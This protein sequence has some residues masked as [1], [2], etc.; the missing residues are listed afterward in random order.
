MHKLFNYA[1]RVSMTVLS[2]ALILT[3]VPIGVF[4]AEIDENPVIIDAAD[5]DK[6]VE[7]V[8]DTTTESEPATKA[9]NE[10]EASQEDELL[11]D[12]VSS[13][14]S[15]TVDV[16]F[17]CQNASVSAYDNYDAI[18]DNKVAVATGNDY[19]FMV[20]ADNGYL[21]KSV[22][23]GD[24]AVAE[25]DGVYTISNITAA[26]TV[27][28]IAVAQGYPTLEELAGQITTATLVDHKE[29]GGLSSDEIIEDYSLTT[30]TGEMM[31]YNGLINVTVSGK[32]LKSHANSKGQNAYWLGI[33]LPQPAE[34]SLYTAQYVSGY[35]KEGYEN[36]FFDADD[37][38]DS[39]DIFYFGT[40]SYATPISEGYVIVEYTNIETDYAVQYMIHVD[41]SEVTFFD[42][43]PT[44]AE[45]AANI[46]KAPLVDRDGKYE[47]EDIAQNYSVTTDEPNPDSD[48]VTVHLKADNLLKHKAGGDAGMGY[49]AGIA[50]PEIVG[51]EFTTEYS[52]DPSSEYY[53]YGSDPSWSS[54]LDDVLRDAQGNI[55]HRTVYFNAAKI[56]AGSGSSYGYVYVKYTSK[57]DSNVS[58]IYRIAVSFE[59]VNIGMVD[60]AIA[61][62]VVA[63]NLGDGNKT[64][65]DLVDDYA[66][67]VEPEEGW[68]VTQGDKEL[69]YTVPVKV[70]AHNL[71]LHNAPGAGAGYWVG[72]GIPQA[73]RQ[74][75]DESK[76]SDKKKFGQYI[77]SR[78]YVGWTPADRSW[79]I[80]DPRA[81]VMDDEQ[82]T[83]GW[84]YDTTLF[85]V[86]KYAGTGK[87]AYVEVRVVDSN[88]EHP[89]AASTYGKGEA[90]IKYELDFSDVTLAETNYDVQITE[91]L[92][93]AKLY[94][95]QSGG[96]DPEITLTATVKDEKGNLAKNVPVAW[97]SDKENIIEFK[98]NDHSYARKYSTST[99]ENGVATAVVRINTSY[100]EAAVANVTATAGGSGMDSVSYELYKENGNL[101]SSTT[102]VTLVR[103]SMTSYSLIPTFT[104]ADDSHYV[105]KWSAVTSADDPT[106]SVDDN[107]I[108]TALKDGTT[109]FKQGIYKENGEL[110]GAGLETEGIYKITVVTSIERVSIRQ[111]QEI[112]A[113]GKMAGGVFFAD[114]YPQKNKNLAYK[115]ESSNTDVLEFMFD[116]DRVPEVTSTKKGAVTVRLTVTDNETGKTYS[117]SKVV[118]V[119][120]AAKDFTVYRQGDYANRA[121]VYPSYTGYVDIP[122]GDSVKFLTEIIAEEGIDKTVKWYS[123]NPAV[124]TVDQSGIVTAVSAGDTIIE[125]YLVDGSDV[126]IQLRVVS[127]ATSISTDQKVINIPQ[128]NGGTAE[129]TLSYEPA[130]ASMPP[131]Y[132]VVGEPKCVTVEPSGG[133]SYTL[134]A[135]K[136]GKETITFRDWMTGLTAS[137][138]VN[139]GTNVKPAT[140]LTTGI[141]EYNIYAGK[142]IQLTYEVTPKDCSNV[143]YNWAVT[144]GDDK[145]SVSDK[146][147]VSVKN[148]VE[149]GECEVTL[150]AVNEDSSL[151]PVTTT[152]KINVQPLPV[153]QSIV[154]EPRSLTLNAPLGDN[155]VETATLSAKV[156]PENAFYSDIKWTSSNEKVVKVH[157]YNTGLI[158]AESEGTATVTATVYKAGVEVVSTSIPV[159]VVSDVDPI[160]YE[161]GRYNE[162]G[163]WIGEVGSFAYTGNP[164]KPEP[165]VYFGKTLLTQNVD[166]KLSWKNNTDV[167][168]SKKNTKATVKATA[169]G[170]YAG[171]QEIEF[172]I[173]PAELSDAVVNNVSAVVKT[174]KTKYG[175]EYVEQLLK[176]TLSY[177]GKALKEGKD[178][179]LYYIDGLYG[180]YEQPGEWAV[181]VT[182]TG[183]FTGTLEAKE[184][185][186]DSATALNISKATVTGLEKDKHFYYDGTAKEPKITLFYQKSKTEKIRLVEGTD[187]DITYD[188]NVEVGTGTIMITGKSSDSNNFYGS[189]KVT[190]KIEAQTRDLAK[191]NGFKVVIDGEPVDVEPATGNEKAG[192]GA[193]VNALTYAKGG[194]KPSS[195]VVMYGDKVL[196]NGVDYSWSNKINTP[197]NDLVHGVVTVTAKGK[198]Y[199]GK[200][201]ITYPIIAQNIGKATIIAEDFVYSA[202]AD[203]YKKNKITIYDVDGK[204]LKEGT[205]YTLTMT[206]D[207]GTRIPTVGSCVTVKITGKEYYFSETTTS[208]RVISGNKKLSSLSYAFLEE[209]DEEIAANKFAVQYK[210]SPV[211]I[212]NDEIVLKI[213]KKVGRTTITTRLDPDQYEIV[214]FQ[215]NNKVGTAT[216]ILRGTGEY[217]GLKSITFKIKK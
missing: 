166:Y 120:P 199:K 89:S 123:F 28:V 44:V 151:A 69:V 13:P 65:A 129:V 140:K 143:T 76:F 216:V 37:E 217:G 121:K 157:P 122:R 175:T 115:W 197:K 6:S 36:A 10:A 83:N 190:F 164:I 4:A 125:G 97:T 213:T 51:D 180:A 198:F 77:A 126:A 93:V 156:Y 106:A 173:V 82:D 159:K 111:E 158:Y 168:K 208:F 102:N 67:T 30:S 27:D 56:A 68:A 137:V 70:T 55:T 152:Y 2:A 163:L 63:A 9:S 186:V 48:M 179:N 178:F 193:A 145:I 196:T 212:T 98:V 141:S 100:T 88:V 130:N 181:T 99:D 86:E 57:K 139:V 61:T 73:L 128:V 169:A 15:E 49:W 40:S 41:M 39:Q 127:Y 80:E 7:P 18:T 170:N 22:K 154:I 21:I 33:A 107:G 117:A 182:G 162:N 8:T 52:Q 62:N 96:N 203:A 108:A 114:V 35:T 5:P 14:A 153:A 94:K 78:Y 192:K 189:K 160:D 1:K 142:E 53:D 144:K 187:Y 138:T 11:D 119:L 17:S 103:P 214:A 54:G 118:E 177:K 165:N 92:G 24:D 135:V 66:V 146:G 191:D 149:S 74:S 215:N 45:L 105:T 42:G 116:T 91:P 79:D 194:T 211:T 207:D 204:P 29:S 132:G 50:I 136:K 109:Y 209:D 71:Q 134:T 205:D 23:I 16:S 147:V 101:P 200:A 85:N 34:N 75:D 195:I 95:A 12:P 110:A 32:N 201:D 202:K 155:D 167:A 60:K 185:L 19:K 172:S 131:Y 176:P 84:R 3:S 148:N 104:L 87:K 64:T 43:L 188:N 20:T 171:S 26:T 112:Y 31:Y 81:Q 38:S 210:G 113:S 133:N 161:T 25:S 59:D 206:A 174:K 46:Q 183:N 90:T 58:K 72:I 150:T 47:K 124:A 184:I